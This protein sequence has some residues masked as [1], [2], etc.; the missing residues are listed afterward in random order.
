MAGLDLFFSNRRGLTFAGQRVSTFVPHHIF[1]S[2]KLMFINSHKLYFSHLVKEEKKSRKAK[3]M[4]YLDYDEVNWKDPKNRY[5]TADSSKTTLD[6]KALDKWSSYKTVTPYCNPQNF[7]G[8]D[9]D[10]EDFRSP[11]DFSDAN[12]DFMGNVT[13]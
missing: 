1:F 2:C 5:I 8:Y 6:Q 3:T 13:R 9:D 11:F 4:V 12:D 7:M 10:E